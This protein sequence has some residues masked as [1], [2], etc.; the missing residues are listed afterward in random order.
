MEKDI[1][2]KKLF[3]DSISKGHIALK[4]VI[5]DYKTPICFPQQNVFRFEE[6]LFMELNEAYKRGDTKLLK[7]LW[8]KVK[9]WE[10][11]Q[12]SK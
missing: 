10:P 7:E 4:P 3:I 1:N 6:K 8:T 12:I 11:E 5:C 9:R 2:P